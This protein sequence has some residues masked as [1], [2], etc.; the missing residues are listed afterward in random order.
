MSWTPTGSTGGGTPG[1]PGGMSNN[2]VSRLGSG[3][4]SGMGRL[5][6]LQQPHASSSSPSPPPGYYSA[7]PQQQ[8]VLLQQQLQLQQQQRRGCTRR[9]QLALRF[10]APA[11]LQ[12]LTPC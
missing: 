1:R 10:K 9:F 2:G 4:G 12:P 7:T 6:S 8:Q 5:G 11:S 3:L